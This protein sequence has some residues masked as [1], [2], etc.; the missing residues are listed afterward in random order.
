MVLINQKNCLTTR[1][2][3]GLPDCII[4]EGR[5][6]GKI[7]V[8]KG[9]AIN[10]ETDAF[11]KAYVD[12]QIQLGNFI[13]I[14][15][16]VEATNNTPEATTEEYQGGIKS[17]VRNG[18][19]EYNFKYLR[20]WKFSSALAS[21]NSFQ[22]YDV[23]FVFSS[24]AVAGATNG[25]SFT[26]FDLGMLNT[27]TYMFTD[28]NA[29]A[30]VTTTIQLINETQ[31]NQDVAIL[32]ASVLDFKV[33]TDLLPITDIVITGR[34][35]VS[36]GKVYFKAKFAMNQASNLGGIAIANLRSLVSGTA[37]VIQAG[38]LTYESTTEEWSYEPTATLTTSTP[39]I[40]QL[41][42]GTNSIDVAKIGTRFYKGASA[43][44]TPVA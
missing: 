13:P 25:T 11:D 20:N 6:T 22:A 1:K 8:P 37:D 44:I 35:D 4:Q 7:L 36:E 19:P 18:L 32:D 40:V 27:G 33:N 41:Y 17:V 30:S 26:G 3:L 9:W 23:L 39:V 43:S 10:L 12:E 38:T 2:N 31:F 34:A 14:L 28:G 42:D 29:S 21:Y 16:A 15:G 5:L 24:G